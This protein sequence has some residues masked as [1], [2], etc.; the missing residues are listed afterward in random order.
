[1]KWLKIAGLGICVFAVVI[2]I[3]AIVFFKSLPTRVKHLPY[4]ELSQSV[5]ETPGGPIPLVL[6]GDK[7]FNKGGISRVV[8]RT[9]AA[10]LDAALQPA[11]FHLVLGILGSPRGTIQ[12][13]YPG[14]GIDLEAISF[15]EEGV[16]Q[17]NGGQKMP[18]AVW[19][20]RYIYFDVPAPLS[21]YDLAVYDRT[22]SDAS[23]ARI[24]AGETDIHFFS[25]PL[26]VD[27]ERY[28]IRL[29]FRVGVETKE[30]ITSVLFGGMGP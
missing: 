5:L 22:L 26:I 24:K 27:S 23:A 14:P 20:D 15:P 19:L 13:Y 25:I 16:Y 3:A 6:E 8:I 28:E 12:P 1:M 21:E 11:P 4:I 2:A 7:F 29:E 30:V 10:N 18:I 9:D 17:K